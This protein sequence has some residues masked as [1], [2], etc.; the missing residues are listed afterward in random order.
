MNSA[1]LLLVAASIFVLAYRVYGS[2]LAERVLRV[3][4]DRATLP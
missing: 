3:N 1:L 4:D 2:F